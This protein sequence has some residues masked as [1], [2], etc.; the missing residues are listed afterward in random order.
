M[1]SGEFSVAQFF[2]G[3][4]Y[5][6]VRQWIDAEEAVRLAREVTQR[7]GAL[8]GAPARVIITDGGDE[9]VFEWK[10]GQGVVFPPSEAIDGQP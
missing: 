3:G 4:A 9:T 6:Y 2:D 8:I 7:P 1:A 10:F 5:E